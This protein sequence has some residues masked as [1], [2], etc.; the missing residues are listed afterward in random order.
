MC[1]SLPSKYVKEESCQVML[2]CSARCWSPQVK[3]QRS[4]LR[5]CKLWEM[6]HGLRPDDTFRL[7]AVAFFFALPSILF[8]ISTY[9]APIDAL[10]RN[11]GS[12]HQERASR[13]QGP[14]SRSRY[15]WHGS[16]CARLSVG[17]IGDGAIK[18]A[19]GES[20]QGSR[21]P[22]QLTKY[23]KLFWSLIYCYC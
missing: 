11:H 17:W 19:S 4:F 22:I 3:A 10:L 23:H 14:F 21:N 16:Q 9:F 8:R 20:R 1:T 6:N 12:L 5:P 15:N 18:R 13:E 2:I 7:S